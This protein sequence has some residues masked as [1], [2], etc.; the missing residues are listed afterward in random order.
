MVSKRHYKIFFWVFTFAFL[1]FSAM[2]LIPEPNG[3]TS[4]GLVINE[5]MAAN[6]AGQTD[7]DGDYSDWIEIHN[8][9]SAAINLSGWSLTDDPNQPEKW[10]FPDIVLGSQAY[11]LLFAS[12]KDRRPAEGFLHTNFRLDQAGEFLGLYN[13]LEQQFMDELSP[14]FSRQL[15]DISFGRYGSSYGYFATPTPGEANDTETVWSGV[16]SKVAFSTER[17]FYEAPF[18]LTLSTPIEGATIRY[19][20]DG[21]AP[22]ESHGLNYTQPIQIDTTTLVRAIAVKPNFLPS[23]EDTHTY[24]FLDDVIKQPNNPPGFPATWGTHRVNTTETSVGDP[25]LADY[26]MSSE[27]A[28]DQLKAALKS[29]PT[30]SVVLDRQSFIDL[31]SNPREKGLAWERAASVEFFEPDQAQAGFQINA[32]LRIQGGIG[33][34]EHSKKHSFRLFFRGEYGATKLDYP[35]FSDAPVQQF[36]TLILRAGGNENFTLLAT[37][38]GARWLV[39]YSRDEWLRRSQLE[40]SGFGSH[41]LFAHVYINGL[42][43]G[44]YNL[45]EKPDEAFMASYFGGDKEDWLVKQPGDPFL[46]VDDRIGELYRLV[47]QGGLEEAKT[48]AAVQQYLDVTQFIDYLILHWYAGATDWPDNNWYMGVQN[49]AGRV[50]FLAWD[51]ELTWI[52]GAAIDHESVSEAKLSRNIVKPIFEPLMQNSDFRMEVAD[53]LYKHLFH[54]GALT[55]ENAQ[56]R[57]LQITQLIDQAIVGEA[58]RWGDTVITPAVSREDWLQGKEFV[59]TQMKNNSAKLISQARKLGYYPNIDPP[60]FNQHGGMI[61]PGFSLTMSSPAVTGPVERVIYYTTDGSDP[62]APISGAVAPGAKTYSG[63]LVLTQT[64]QVKA[65]LWVPD[66]ASETGSAWSALHEAAFNVVEPD[67]SLQITEIMYNPLDE[68]QYEFIELSNSGN[69]EVNLANLAFSEGIRYTFPATV[70]PLAPG[71]SVV[72]VSNSAAFAARYPD[73]PIVGVYEGQL[74]NQGERIS[75]T[76]ATGRTIF[77]VEY[78]DENEWPLSADGQGDSLILAEAGGDPNQ[79]INWRASGRL[80]GAPGVNELV[81]LTP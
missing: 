24:L 14:Q 34:Y 56:Q 26:A 40:M 7:E 63:P 51:G 5:F 49:P 70:P 65:R 15:R 11:L 22:S 20:V 1:V 33:R 32:G 17:G 41:G 72:L 79:P 25:V 54:D 67:I 42:Y 81:R 58:A 13:V 50:K 47:A 36:D 75:L 76:D 38:K 30:I 21:S 45:V 12:G 6:G 35:L 23:V 29:I 19:T 61:E 48:Y 78:D 64:T 71:G 2:Q 9:S 46:D 8:R 80:H 53:R 68:E 3:I 74:S 57:W 55:D 31:Y 16:V 52:N 28:S 60:T 66:P 62:R 44:L 77:S 10:I 39:T 18:S 43:W 73:V 27:I 4:G 69:R 59:L 37:L